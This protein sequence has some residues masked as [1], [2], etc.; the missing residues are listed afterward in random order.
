MGGLDTVPET[1]DTGMLADGCQLGHLPTGYEPVLSVPETPM[2]QLRSSQALE[3][4]AGSASLGREQ[5]QTTEQNLHRTA[6]TAKLHV[7]L[8]HTQ[9]EKSLHETGLAGRHVC[10]VP[11]SAP[12]DE[13]L[14]GT[15]SC[16]ARLHSRHEKKFSACSNSM[17]PEKR[18][19]SLLGKL[20]SFSHGHRDTDEQ[21]SAMC[22]D[23]S[24]AE[25]LFEIDLGLDPHN[26][27]NQ[28][29]FTATPT[30]HPC[31][32]THIKSNVEA[33]QSPGGLDNPVRKLDPLEQKAS[34]TLSAQASALD[35]CHK[36]KILQK[37]SE[38]SASFGPYTEPLPKTALGTKQSRLQQHSP[39]KS[40]KA[41]LPSNCVEA[42]FA[43]VIDQTSVKAM[44]Q[45]T[46]RDTGGNE[47]L[48]SSAERD[49]KSAEHPVQ[50][51]RPVV[52][53]TPSD[54]TSSHVGTGLSH[55]PGLKRNQGGVVGV[56]SAE[57]EEALKPHIAS[58]GSGF[59]RM[60]RVQ[61]A[62]KKEV[63]LLSFIALE[64]LPC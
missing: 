31:S 45:A 44:H 6:I 24:K 51:E 41:S 60:N 28:S 30:E 55:P 40:L 56:Q 27:P 14:A 54:H 34:V 32:A 22:P 12:E 3:Y 59:R 2:A 9:G 42:P 57:Q 11:D 47:R 38:N 43:A 15:S 26:T 19:S 17:Q 4:A 8:N 64:A 58:N 36:P 61:P 20:H 33:R 29:E 18:H 39:S 23:L 10:K 52:G 5:M 50:V 53:S 48:Q 37:S 62:A 35:Q 7:A 1:P 63:R 21:R 49:V 25:I 13:Y 16:S 46:S